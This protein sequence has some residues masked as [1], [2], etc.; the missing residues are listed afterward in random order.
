M[1]RRIY[2]NSDQG[3]IL[4][5]PDYFV[6]QLAGHYHPD[7]K[8]DCRLLEKAA[9]SGLGLIV[10]QYVQQNASPSDYEAD[11]L[12]IELCSRSGFSREDAKRAIRLYGNMV[13]WRL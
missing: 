11:N 2:Q 13:G 7:Y 5:D 6:E 8:E 10:L 4:R 3:R 9:R 12:S 1:L